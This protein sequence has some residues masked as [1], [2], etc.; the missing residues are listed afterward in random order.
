MPNS[1]V[2]P[3]AE[4]EPGAVV[5]E[6]TRIWRHVHVMKDAVIGR[7]C[8]LGQGCF[9]ASRVRI[10]DGCHIQN[11]VSLYAGLEL[12]AEVFVGPSAVFTNVSRPRVRYPRTAE[13]YEP[14]RIGQ[15]ASIGANAT[16]VCGHRIGEY[17]FVAA[18]A[19]VTRDVPAHALVMGVP[20]RI[21]GWLCACG[22]TVS[23]QA[24][25]PAEP[26]RCARCALQAGHSARSNG[27]S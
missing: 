13:Q 4:V 7:N 16:I 19:V 25:P 8:V 11:N 23:N 18:G 2:H 20:A 3:T 15:G 9:V 12:D 1:F 17:A 26:I 14:T 24:D 6:G 21:R 22:A 5:G 27:R 10:G